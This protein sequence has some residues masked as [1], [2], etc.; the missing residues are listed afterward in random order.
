LSKTILQLSLND[1]HVPSG[2]K[3]GANLVQVGTTGQSLGWDLQVLSKHL[4]GFST[5]QVTGVP[6]S[7]NND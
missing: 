2:H 1:A 5:E 7:F 6:Q 4:Y 3:I